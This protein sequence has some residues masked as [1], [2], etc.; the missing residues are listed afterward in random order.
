MTAAL[1]DPG[2]DDSLKRSIAIALLEIGSD[3]GLPVLASSLKDP[4]TSDADDAAVATALGNAKTPATLGVLVDSFKTATDKLQMTL[5]IALTGSSE[6]SE[7]LLQ[8]IQ[9]GKASAR[10]LQEQN[11]LDRLAANKVDNLDARVKQLTKGMPALNDK[12]IKL[13]NDRRAEFAGVTNADPRHGQEIFQKN[14][15]VCHNLDGKAHRS[16]RNWMVSASAAP[17]ASSKMCSIRIATSIRHPLQHAD[18]QG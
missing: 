7:A 10:L 5:A 17:T 2:S 3:Q 9:D 8:A 4:A 14:C 6:G 16:A 1:N 11:I 15:M 12:L 18:P 13:V